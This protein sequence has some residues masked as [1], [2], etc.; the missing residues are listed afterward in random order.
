V[1]VAEG[2]VKTGVNVAKKV[3]WTGGNLLKKWLGIFWGKE[4]EEGEENGL[5]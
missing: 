1:A 5:T 4:T 2:T 3:L